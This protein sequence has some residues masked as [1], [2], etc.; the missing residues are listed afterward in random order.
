LIGGWLR[1]NLHF[2]IAATAFNQASARATH[3]R[4]AGIRRDRYRNVARDLAC[5]HLS[6]GASNNSAENRMPQQD[7][8]MD[9][10]ATSMTGTEGTVDELQR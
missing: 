1:L 2:G 5:R 3:R 10:E 6:R 7:D 4:S 8:W 9:G